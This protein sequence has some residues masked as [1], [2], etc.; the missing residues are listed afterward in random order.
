MHSLLQATRCLISPAQ[1]LH[2]KTSRNAYNLRTMLHPKR[3][4][5]ANENRCTNLDAERMT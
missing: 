4:G 2:V 3:G 1:I 5:G